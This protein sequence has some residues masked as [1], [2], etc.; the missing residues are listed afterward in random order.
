MSHSIA[1]S[2]GPGGL[3]MHAQMYLLYCVLGVVLFN[4]VTPL[5]ISFIT[6]ETRALS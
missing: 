5:S 1:L 3:K 4:P 2:R 6:I